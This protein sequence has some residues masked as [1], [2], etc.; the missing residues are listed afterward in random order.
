L[1]QGLAV[2]VI[3]HTNESFV[4]S[5]SYELVLGIEPRVLTIAE[6]VA[7]AALVLHLTTAYPAVNNL[8]ESRRLDDLEKRRGLRCQARR[9]IDPWPLDDARLDQVAAMS[10]IGNDY[11]VSTYPGRWQARLTPINVTASALRNVKDERRI[12]RAEPGFLWFF[13][14]GAVHKGLDLVLEA[15]AQMPERTL[16]IAGN[17][18]QER[19][20]MELYRRELHDLPNVHWHG[21]MKTTSAAFDALIDRC[22]F[23]IAPSCS[24]GMSPAAATCLQAGLLPAVTPQTGITLPKGAGRYLEPC[25][26]EQIQDTADALSALSPDERVEQTLAVQAQALD[27]FSRP[28]F[29]ATARRY[30]ATVLSAHREGHEQPSA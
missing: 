14:S 1:D 28:R 15:F 12:R 9:H 16:H 11:T 17:I 8:A 2:E 19:D 7:D 5:G 22:S 27:A 20:F 30:L 18:A 25:T 21:S 4:P 26:I 10:L 13:G 24:E 29:A 23:V 3:D 6:Q